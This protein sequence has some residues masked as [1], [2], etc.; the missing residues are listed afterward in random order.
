[1]ALDVSEVFDMALY[2]AL[3]LFVGH[4]GV[5]EELI[6]IF[7]HLEPWVHGTHSHIA[8]PKPVH[9]VAP[10]SVARRCRCCGEVP[11]PREAALVQYRRRCRKG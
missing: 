4:M 6:R 8:W 7:E 3:A 5:L 1:M 9:P 10:A 11:P 2:N